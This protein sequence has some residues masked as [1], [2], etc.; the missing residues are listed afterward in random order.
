MTDA[1]RAFWRRVRRDQIGGLRF[2]RQRVIGP[3]IVDFCCPTA[4]LVVEI[5]GEWHFLAEGKARDTVR[6]EF[7]GRS[8]YRVLRFDDRRVLL[9]LDQVISELWYHLQCMPNIKLKF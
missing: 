6:D 2:Y 3:Y 8:G 7:L 5:D 9:E 1:E 4:G